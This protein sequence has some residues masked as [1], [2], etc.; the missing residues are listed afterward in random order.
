MFQVTE[1]TGCP[2]NEKYLL[3][4]EKKF[5]I[6]DFGADVDK[7]PV[8][9]TMAI[10]SAIQKASEE[11]GT[12]II[13]KGDFRVYTIHL[14]SG[15]NIYMCEVSVIHAAKTDIKKSYEL[16]IGEGSNYEEPEVNLYVGL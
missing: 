5:D 6:R 4:E 9:N 3:K 8:E 11:G 2:F 13:P 16:Q 12:V 1:A 10:N 15:V 7:S 14:M